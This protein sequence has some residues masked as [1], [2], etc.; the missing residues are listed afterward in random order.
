MQSLPCEYSGTM[1]E[2]G[3]DIIEANA[4]RQCNEYGRW[5]EPDVSSCISE[6]TAML[7]DIKNVRNIALVLYRRY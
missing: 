7:C 4:T 3:C 6:V 2:G 1:T 5:E